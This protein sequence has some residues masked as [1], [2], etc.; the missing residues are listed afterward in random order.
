MFIAYNLDNIPLQN[1]AGAI[2]GKLHQSNTSTREYINF[3]PLSKIVL[4]FASKGYNFIVRLLTPK[5][6]D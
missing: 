1:S 6:F 4:E 3:D 2:S 5:L